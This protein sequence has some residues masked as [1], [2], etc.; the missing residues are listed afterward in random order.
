MLRNVVT[1]QCSC[2]GLRRLHGAQR[3]Q[4]E[5]PRRPPSGLDLADRHV[6][7]AA[8]VTRYSTQVCSVEHDKDLRTG[9]APT[10]RNCGCLRRSGFDGF[11]PARD[12]VQP[13]PHAGMVG[14]RARQERLK[15]SRRLAKGVPR[16]QLGLQP[17]QFP[18]AAVRQHM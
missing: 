2:D 1:V 3:G 15:Q 4:C 6:E 8:V 11:D 7:V 9:L 10:T 18:R 5:A 14:R 17:P 13:V 12:A 16:A